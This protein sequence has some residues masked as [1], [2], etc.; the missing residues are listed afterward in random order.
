MK[1][2]ADIDI[3]MTLALVE[4]V[5]SKDRINAAGEGIKLDCGCKEKHFF[6][7]SSYLHSNSLKFVYYLD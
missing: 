7:L 5:G 3:P 6:M 4:D 2:L 1:E